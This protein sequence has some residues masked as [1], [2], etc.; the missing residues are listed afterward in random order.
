MRQTESAVLPDVQSQAD[1]RNLPIDAAGVT[2][3]RY[4]GAIQAGRAPLQT[5]ATISMSVG[6]AATTKGTH[7]SRFLELLEAQKEALDQSRFKLLV[8]EML[9]RLKAASGAL[10]LRFPYF[11]RKTA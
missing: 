9:A 4:P 2:G 5:V 11:V 3:I 10:E 1:V 7:M 8:L 6:L